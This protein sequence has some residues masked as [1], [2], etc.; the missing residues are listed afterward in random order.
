MVIRHIGVWSVA[1]LYGGLS[2]AMGLIIGAIVAL[3]A[4]AGLL[5]RRR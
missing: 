5:R 1:R 4:L 2:A 3:V